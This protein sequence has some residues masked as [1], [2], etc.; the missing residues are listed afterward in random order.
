M[1]IHLGDKKH[2][3]QYC[4]KGFVRKDHLNSHL[5]VHLGDGAKYHCPVCSK[6]FRV[7][8][9]YL[10]HMNLHGLEKAYTVT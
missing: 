7:R 1:L 6:M 2:K 3:C 9:V 5:K 4:D 8:E 10:K